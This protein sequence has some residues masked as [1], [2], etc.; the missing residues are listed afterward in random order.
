MFYKAED[1]R[2]MF[3]LLN[4]Y[5]INYLLTKNIA[6][7]LP[8]K[9]KLGKDIDLIVHI[10]DYEKFQAVLNHFGYK[11]IVHPH[12]KE[13]GWFFMYGA[14][15][16]LFMTNPA[17]GLIV[18]AYAELCTKS[19]ERNAWLPLDKIVQNSIWQNKVWDA[20]NQWWIMDDENL[21]V[22]LLTRSVFEK[23]GFSDAYVREIEKRKNFLANPTARQ[24]LEKIFFKFTDTLI[25]KVC[26]GRYAEILL[27]YLTF[28][29]Y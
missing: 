13:R 9:L 2:A 4:D 19:I 28:T 23:N 22:Y 16:N 7:E 24:K 27:S 3:Q 11:K 10:E 1:V 14:H 20:A 26:A 6:D 5:E 17:T 15:E 8:D 21:V 29:D 25:E 18:D 12:G